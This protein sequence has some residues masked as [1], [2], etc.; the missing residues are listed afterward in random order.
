LVGDQIA[1]ITPPEQQTE[2]AWYAARNAAVN[3]GSES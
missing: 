1:N 3:A 2:P